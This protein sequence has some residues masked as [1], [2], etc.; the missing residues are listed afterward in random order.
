MKSMR[1]T[2]LDD[3]SVEVAVDSQPILDDMI[4]QKEYISNF[5]R[6]ELNNGN[7]SVN[8]IKAKSETQKHLIT[9]K[10]KFDDMLKRSE[11]L[12]ILAKNLHLTPQ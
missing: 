8:F 12:R 9:P 1:P 11:A 7:I 2:L 6:Q 4:S 10:E 3:G 5:F